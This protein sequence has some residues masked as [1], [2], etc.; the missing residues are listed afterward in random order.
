MNSLLVRYSIFNSILALVAASACYFFNALGLLLIFDPTKISLLILVILIAVSV[1]IGL[2]RE[3]AS[4]WL[5]KWTARLLPAVGL[6]GTI[7]GAILLLHAFGT[8]A[9]TDSAHLAQEL[10]ASMAPVFI[11]TGAGI[12]GMA[13]ILTQLVFVYGRRGDDENE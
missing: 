13:L 12:G 5:I 10:M 3:N 2:R 7:T 9:T 11:T 6:I 1:Y 8:S 4:L